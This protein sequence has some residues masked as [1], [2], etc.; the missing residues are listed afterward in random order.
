[1]AV[2]SPPKF[3]STKMDRLE[4]LWNLTKRTDWDGD[5]GYEKG[6]GEMG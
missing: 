2:V 1:M 3:S 6:G 5:G 4:T